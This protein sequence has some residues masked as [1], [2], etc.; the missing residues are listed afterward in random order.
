[1]WDESSSNPGGLDGQR[2]GLLF[3][4]WWRAPHNGALAYVTPFGVEES[5]TFCPTSYS[6]AGERCRSASRLLFSAER[7]SAAF[8]F[9]QT[10]RILRRCSAAEGL[11]DWKQQGLETV[12]SHEWGHTCGGAWEGVVRVL[13][14]V[15]SGLDINGC[16]KLFWKDSKFT[17]IQ[18]EHWLLY[19]VPKCHI[20]SVV[21]KIYIYINVRGVFTFVRYC[22]CIALSF[23]LHSYI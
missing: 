17:V 23:K 4:K 18:S 21:M 19:L 7:V 22:M 2:K 12:A 3:W 6:G 1:M 9:L 13:T 5:H 11:L 20:F 14:F 15:A 16:V 10:S 8:T